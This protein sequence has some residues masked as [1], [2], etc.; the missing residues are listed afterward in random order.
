MQPD[1]RN[2]STYYV[3]ERQFPEEDYPLYCASYFILS[4]VDS[5]EKLVQGYHKDITANSVHLYTVYLG[6][7]ASKINMKIVDGK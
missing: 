5:V 2:T 7:L 6:I 4:H 1:R 3:S